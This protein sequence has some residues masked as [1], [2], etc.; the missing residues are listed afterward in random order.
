MRRKGFIAYNHNHSTN[1]NIKKG[2]AK[3]CSSVYQA[4]CTQIFSSL[5]LPSFLALVSRIGTFEVQ[6]YGLE[7]LGGGEPVSGEPRGSF[8]QQGVT[9]RVSVR[10]TQLLVP[11]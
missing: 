8:R 9:N 7:Y 1:T 4:P 5:S 11:L 6:G 2:K 10:T 3:L